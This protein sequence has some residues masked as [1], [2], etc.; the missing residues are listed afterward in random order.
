[1][2]LAESKSKVPAAQ[3]FQRHLYDMEEDNYVLLEI[4]EQVDDE[5]DVLM[6]DFISMEEQLETQEEE[7]AETLENFEE[8]KKL[9]KKLRWDFAKMNRTEL[10]EM[11]LELNNMCDPFGE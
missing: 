7:I 5:F 1:M 2:I 3:K 9:V 10:K 8:V 11:I 6:S 4:Y